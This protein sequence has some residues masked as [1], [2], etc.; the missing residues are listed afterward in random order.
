MTL[1]SS[2][3]TFSLYNEDGRFD[4]DSDTAL[5]RF[6][7]DGQRCIVDYG[8]D[9]ADGIEAIPGG[10]WQL[11]TWKVS[12]TN[13]QFTM[14]DALA[15]INKTT[16]ETSVYD[17]TVRS[18]YAL[19]Q[20]VFADAGLTAAEYY[21]DPYLA[22]VETSAPLPVKTHAQCLQ[23]IAHAG[24]CRLYVDRDS[25]ITLERLISDLEPV[26]SSTTD[27][28]DYS[29]AGTAVQDGNVTYATFEPSFLRVDGTQTI[30]PSDGSYVDAG[31]TALTPSDAEGVFT[32]NELILTYDDPT[33]VFGVEVDWGTY[34]PP[35]KVRMSC[36]V[37]G[38]WTSK[39]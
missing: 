12:G 4:V 2:S 37:D 20:A 18:L 38:V 30:I 21:I 35:A 31:W 8:I 28:T 25:V 14:E 16:Y 39:D 26:A 33:N 15:K 10:R 6:L 27:Q 23:L 17:A 7:A 29:V 32:A 11:S 1:P 9:T 22:N 3:L 24:R 36:R 5:Q 34:P 13:A 19:A